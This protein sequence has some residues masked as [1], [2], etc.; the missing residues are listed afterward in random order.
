MT[1]SEDTP[2]I[3]KTNRVDR[4]TPRDYRERLQAKRIFTG[5]AV[6]VLVGILV[7]ASYTTTTTTTSNDGYWTCTKTVKE[8]EHLHE[9]NV[10]CSHEDR[11]PAR[12]SVRHKTERNLHPWNSPEQD[13]LVVAD[14]LGELREKLFKIVQSTDSSADDSKANTKSTEYET[15]FWHCAKQVT[16]SEDYHK[17]DLKC[18]SNNN[19]MS[20]ATKGHELYWERDTIHEVDPA[21]KNVTTTFFHIGLDDKQKD[22]HWTWNGPWSSS[23]WNPSN[24]FSSWKSYSPTA[25]DTVTEAAP[26]DA[27]TNQSVEE[28]E[29]PPDQAAP[30]D[31]TPEQPVEESEPQPDQGENTTKTVHHRARSHRHSDGA[32]EAPP[33]AEDDAATSPRHRSRDSVAEPLEETT[34]VKERR[35]SSRRREDS[36]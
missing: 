11:E 7:L 10:E 1:P 21:D 25:N 35:H 12:R 28:P 20:A 30:E 22:S 14:V 8:G 32:V 36:H 26:D 6:L 4:E 2:L 24:W 18:Q 5:S 13:V 16:N 29:A 27:T 17:E 34:T 19:D 9:Q 31:A 23:N 3:A 33:P 15:L